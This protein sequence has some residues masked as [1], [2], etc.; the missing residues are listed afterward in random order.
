[1]RKKIGLLLTLVLAFLV[2]GQSAYALPYIANGTNKIFYNNYET[3]FRKDANGNYNEINSSLGPVTLIA[4]DIFVGIINVQE[5]TNASN[6]TI[7]DNPNGDQLT[8]IFAQEITGFLINPSGGFTVDVKPTSITT[9]NPLV[10]NSFST[11]LAANEMFGVYLDA[12]GS[13]P[14]TTAG[15][16]SAGVAAATNGLSWM[17]LGDADPIVVPGT[18][19]NTPG[20]EYAWS[21]ITS[22]FGDSFADF[23]G[24]QFLGLSVLSYAGGLPWIGNPLLN[25]PT[26]NRF[27]SNVQFYANSELTINPDYLTGGSRW[28]YESNDPARVNGVVPEPATALLLGLG[29][30]GFAGVARRKCS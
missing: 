11:G 17:T 20:Q 15:T 23:E 9:F 6:Q 12:G 24:D 30:L 25:D 22:N 8:G 21:A 7:W 4:T 13:T 3:V 26:E 19:F 18:T 29:L 16:I 1:M 14:F 27:N 2:V 10:G 28:V 5:I